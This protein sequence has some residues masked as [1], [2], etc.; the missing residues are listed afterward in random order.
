MSLFNTISSALGLSEDLGIVL[1]SD[2]LLT[3][4]RSAP[5][6]IFEIPLNA[7]PPIPA[8]PPKRLPPEVRDGMTTRL[9]L[10]E[11]QSAKPIYVRGEMLDF[12]AAE[13]CFKDAIQ[14]LT[15]SK[16]GF[17]KPRVVCCVPWEQEILRKRAILDGIERA[18]ARTVY[19]TQTAVTIAV[20]MG[21]DILGDR[22]YGILSVEKDWS[23]F[24]V[25][26][27]ACQIAHRFIPIG[28]DDI[29]DPSVD[30][31]WR[32]RLLD[33]I[34]SALA[35]LRPLQMEKLAES[36]IYCTSY[37]AT[38]TRQSEMG[39]LIGVPCRLP[40]SEGSTHSAVLGLRKYLEHLDEWKRSMQSETSKL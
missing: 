26:S 29:P 17:I 30:S 3:F 7:I 20:G 21:L 27:Y 36:G 28:S 6:K 19:L 15:T 25:V 1:L 5:E 38:E 23:V 11:F 40:K 10:G 12:E 2:R 37:A 9:H 8:M 35:E 18:G 16:T 31:P 33:G 34:A 13:S 24:A 4:S 39:R 22:V 32:D 14:K